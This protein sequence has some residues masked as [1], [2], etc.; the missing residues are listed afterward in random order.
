MKT[1]AI[2]VTHEVLSRDAK[3]K[4]IIPN[5]C[6]QLNVPFKVCVACLTPACRFSSLAGT[7]SKKDGRFIN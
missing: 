7:Q 5:I 3:R 2:L 6:E 1:G 4:F